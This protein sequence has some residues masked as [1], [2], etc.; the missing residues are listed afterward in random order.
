MYGPP[1]TVD[2]AAT[3]TVGEGQLNGIYAGLGVS[4]FE[5]PSFNGVGPVAKVPGPRAAFQSD[6]R[7][8]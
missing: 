1:Q 6:S 4:M 3:R 7:G 2:A 8:S 5:N